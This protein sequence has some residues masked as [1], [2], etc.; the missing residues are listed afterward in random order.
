MAELCRIAKA[1]EGK[2]VLVASHGAVIRAFWALICH[3]P[4][5][6]ATGKHPFP[7]NSSYCV[8]EFDGE[9]FIPISFSNDAHLSVATHLHI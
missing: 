6:V 8:V 1:H 3:T 2:T 5:D 9:K 4:L 7:S